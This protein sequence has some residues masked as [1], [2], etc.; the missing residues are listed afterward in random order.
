MKSALTIITPD[1]RPGNHAQ[2]IRPAQAWWGLQFRA[3]SKRNVNAGVAY[4]RGILA[5]RRGRVAVAT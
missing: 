4:P 3:H 2:A 1:N 5:V